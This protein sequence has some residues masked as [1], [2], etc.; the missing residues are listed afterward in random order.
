MPRGIPTLITILLLAGAL[1]VSAWYLN[2]GSAQTTPAIVTSRPV[3]AGDWPP[4][5][6]MTANVRLDQTADGDN[7]WV[8][9]RE[10]L[11]K[12]LLKYQPEILGTQELSPAQGAYLTKELSQ[13]YSYYPRAGVGPAATSTQ[14]RSA[15]SELLS[16]MSES[17]A[18]LDT[19]YYR[20]DRFDILEG[21]A[22]LVLPREPQTNASENTFFSMAVLKEKRAAGK[23]PATIIVVDIHFRH[24]EAFAIRCAKEMRRKLDAWS[25]KYPGAGIILM[26]D[27]N[28]GRG[29]QLYATLTAADPATGAP[30]PLA[31]TFDYSKLD[32]KVLNGTYMQFAG[33]PNATWPTDL[34]FA[35]GALTEV[36]SAEI[37]RDHTSEGRYPSDHYF[38]Q[39]ELQFPAKQN[40]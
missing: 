19:I 15:V 11:V 39:T 3:P 14:T 36:H 4:L 31:D 33:K 37:L 13:W 32:P 5:R 7:G 18:S 38:V 17:L 40:P 30:A 1:A 29:T 26:G 2:R 24:D 20:T 12:T 23:P 28:R 6:V 16:A 9:R 8:K 10:L 22:G 25:G 34:I 27:I 35:G 21:E